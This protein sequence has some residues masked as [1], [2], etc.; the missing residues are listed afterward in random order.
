MPIKKTSEI[1]GSGP[2]DPPNGSPSVSISVHPSTFP[3]ITTNKCT[4]YVPS[5]KPMMLV[6]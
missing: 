3:T 4:S 2:S 5:E 1:T 6:L